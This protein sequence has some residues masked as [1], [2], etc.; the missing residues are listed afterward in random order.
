V[1]EACGDDH[2]RPEQDEDAEREI[3]SLHG[4]RFALVEGCKFGRC[5]RRACGRVRLVAREDQLAAE[6][7]AGDRAERVE[8]LCEIQ[9]AFRPRRI[10]ER[11]DQGVGRCLEKRQ[12][13]GDDEER[14]EEEA[15]GPRLCRRVEEERAHA[16][17][18]EPGDH[19]GLVAKRLGEARRRKSKGE[20]AD[21]EG[22]LHQSR[23]KIAEH[24]RL[25]E[26]RDQH[27]VEAVGEPPEEKQAGDEQQREAVPRCGGRRRAQPDG[28]RKGG[29]ISHAPP[30]AARRSCRARRFHPGTGGPGST[31]GASQR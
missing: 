3:G 12:P 7:D 21:I 29:T 25:L 23:L 13:A 28:G 9:P 22:G 20:I 27:I 10:A 17:E 2:C 4:Q 15:V 5:H 16:I 8:R 30:S 26:L 19:R 1:G 18:D 6:H 11:G 14:A 31:E 24:E